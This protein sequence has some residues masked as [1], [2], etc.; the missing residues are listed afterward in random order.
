MK[1]QDILS[2]VDSF[3]QD[4]GWYQDIDLGN[5]IKTKSK[6]HFGEEIDH[7]NSR[8][9]EIAN[10][11]PENLEGKSVLDIGCNAGYIALKAKSFGAKRV[12]GID[13][14]QGYIDQAKFCAEVKNVDIEYRLLDIGKL[15]Q[16][17]EQFD[18][19]FCV[20]ILYHCKDLLGAVKSVA[21]VTKEQLILETAMHHTESELPL[22]RYSRN[23]QFAPTQEGGNGLPGHWH[24]N[25]ATLEA[26]FA[27]QGFSKINR[28]FQ[29][30]RRGGIVA[31][32]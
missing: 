6:S 1:Q 13:L 5:G 7:P 3:E 26:M 19:V 24:P 15:S 17:K 29:K 32:K 9:L 10:A 11:V 4:L 16:L 18:L 8:W 23:S 2:K 27:E 31:W 14:K 28:H 22:V 12:V 20:G 25:F 30:G 21:D